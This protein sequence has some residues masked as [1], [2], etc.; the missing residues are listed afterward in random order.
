MSNNTVEKL[1][2]G[3]PI[4]QDS[5]TTATDAANVEYEGD[6]ARDGYVIMKH[7][8]PEGIMDRIQVDE[9][10]SEVAP[11]GRYKRF[12]R[13]TPAHEVVEYFIKDVSKQP[14]MDLGVSKTN[15]DR[16]P[17]AIIVGQYLPD[18]RQPEIQ[19]LFASPPDYVYVTIAMSPRLSSDE[20]MPEF[21]RESHKPAVQTFHGMLTA[22]TNK[23]TLYKGWAMFWTSQLAYKWPQGSGGSYIQLRYRKGE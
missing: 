23:T 22:K 12:V 18:G 21:I 6:A 15:A 3:E 14:L 10:F 20:G 19:K 16:E 8:I 4:S 13:D 1:A 5:V 11:S 7:A 17:D 9:R 2:E